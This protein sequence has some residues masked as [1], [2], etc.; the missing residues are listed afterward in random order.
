MEQPKVYSEIDTDYLV[1]TYSI[2]QSKQDFVRA[3][4]QL[5]GSDNT[6]P[7]AGLNFKD[8]SSFVLPKI[9]IYKEKK[10]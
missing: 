10:K 3:S 5:A 7:N 8:F 2:H 4:S 1:K 6:P 9:I